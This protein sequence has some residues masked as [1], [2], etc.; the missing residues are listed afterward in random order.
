MVI[1]IYIC[2][3]NF[4]MDESISGYVVELSPVK[5]ARDKKRKYF[6]F[7]LKTESSENRTVC[8]SPEKHRLLSSIC[9]SKGACEIKR[10][11]KSGSNDDIIVNYYSAIKRTK[12]DFTPSDT[13]KKF[14][15]VSE[16]NNESQLYDIVNVV[17]VV[18]NISDNVLVE[19]DGVPLHFKKVQL[20]MMVIVSH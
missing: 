5:L 11:S 6:H 12:L 3:N 15:T 10:F 7:T 4:V 14:F 17:S 18:S 1:I 20:A 16:M 8:F 13:M 2:L 9:D 19:K